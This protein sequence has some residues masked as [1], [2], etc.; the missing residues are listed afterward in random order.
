METCLLAL[1]FHKNKVI[2]TLDQCSLTLVNFI[3]TLENLGPRVNDSW[4]SDPSEYPVLYTRAKKKHQVHKICS[5]YFIAWSRIMKIIKMKN[6]G[7][8]TNWFHKDEN[9]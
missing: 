6:D 1:S 5:I 9:L 8:L 2:L 3:L 4:D 7:N